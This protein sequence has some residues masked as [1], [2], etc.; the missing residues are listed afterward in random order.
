LLALPDLTIGAV[1]LPVNTRHPGHRS[2]L[3]VEV[4]AGEVYEA[5]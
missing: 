4:W 3:T 2:T 5:R 1:P